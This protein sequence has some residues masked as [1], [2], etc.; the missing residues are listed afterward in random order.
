MARSFWQVCDL[1]Q[2][3]NLD[4]SNARAWNSRGDTDRFLTILGTD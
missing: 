2:G 1:N 3:P 4:G